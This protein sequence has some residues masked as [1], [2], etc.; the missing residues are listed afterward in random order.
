MLSKLLCLGSSMKLGPDGL[1][2]YVCL[3][4]CL[5]VQYYGP[6]TLTVK[7]IFTVVKDSF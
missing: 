5:T 1:L 7:Q 2:M 6:A 4:F 3:L